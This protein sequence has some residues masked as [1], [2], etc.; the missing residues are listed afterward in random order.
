[1]TN[2]T[3]NNNDFDANNCIDDAE[4][5]EYLQS[6]TRSTTAIN[7]MDGARLWN[8]RLNGAIRWLSDVE[9][10]LANPTDKSDTTKLEDTKE[11][12]EFE[13]ALLN[14]EVSGTISRWFT[15]TLLSGVE[16]GGG[17]ADGDEID[18]AFMQSDEDND[19]QAPVFE[20][21]EQDGDWWEEQYSRPHGLSWTKPGEIQEDGTLT[22]EKVNFAVNWDHLNKVAEIR[23]GLVSQLLW[24]VEK[25]NSIR[26]LVRITK[27]AGLWSYHAQQ[28]NGAEK[29]CIEKA[30]TFGI[31]FRRYA[32]V[33]NRAAQ[34]A[35]ELKG[36]VKG[37]EAVETLHFT[38]SE[39]EK[40]VE[41]ELKKLRPWLTKKVAKDLKVFGVK[42]FENPSD[43]SDSEDILDRGAAQG[44]FCADAEFAAI[45][46]VTMEL[47][48]EE[49]CRLFD[50]ARRNLCKPTVTS[51]KMSDE[52]ISDWMTS[53]VSPIV[54]MP[55]LTVKLA[56]I[57]NQ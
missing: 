30:N 24:E 49:T 26:N 9:A 27:W 29:G 48:M 51:W 23:D 55:R 25:A 12:L 2:N 35:C 46:K 17:E 42:I 40:V 32:E 11:F 52:D 5:E 56:E 45:T 22:E 20:T 47:A 44:E 41:A 6:L 31:D 43:E 54:Q 13:I 36:F 1:M 4:Y 38:N 18:P 7:T 28:R 34:K 39:E 37:G 15:R 57:F 14:D 53:P 8:K 19:G 3:I 33:C 21:S 10:E 50:E 16:Y